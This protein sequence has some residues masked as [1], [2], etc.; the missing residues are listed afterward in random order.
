MWCWATRTPKTPVEKLGEPGVPGALGE[1]DRPGSTN[2]EAAARLLIS[3]STVRTHVLH[4]YGKLGVN[5]RAAAVAAGFRRGLLD[6]DQ[7]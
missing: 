3:E 1:P 2:R 4:I 6:P 5:D 7:G